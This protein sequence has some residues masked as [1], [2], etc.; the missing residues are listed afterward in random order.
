MPE[1][2]EVTELKKK[3]AELKTEFRA[4]VQASVDR[5]DAYNDA[6]AALAKIANSTIPGADFQ[7]IAREALT[8]IG[9]DNLIRTKADKPKP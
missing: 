3:L 2:D 9:C 6:L 5:N 4:Y 7:A 1:V 8:E